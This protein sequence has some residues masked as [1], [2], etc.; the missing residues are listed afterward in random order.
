MKLSF[1]TAGAVL[2][3]AGT[4]AVAAPQES[5]SQAGGTINGTF[6]SDGRAF[7]PLNGVATFT[8]TGTYAPKRLIIGG[9]LTSGG[10]GSWQL[11][12]SI[13]VTPPSGN[14]FVVNASVLGATYT[15]FNLP[16]NFAAVTGGP[17]SSAA[18]TW[19]LRFYETW[20]DASIDATW[21]N[22][23]VTLDD[24][25]PAFPAVPGTAFASN[26]WTDVD[27]DGTATSGTPTVLT[28]EYTGTSN[29]SAV[30]IG[31][32]AVGRTGFDINKDDTQTGE[33][34]VGVTP[35]GGTEIVRQ[36]AAGPRT[37]SPVTHA[38]LVVNL[39]GPT[40]PGTWT[41]RLFEGSRNGDAVA[42]DSGVD[43][44]WRRFFLALLPSDPPASETLNL[45]DGVFVTDTETLSGTGVKWYSFTI[46]AID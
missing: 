25:D 36:I 16:A 21:S 35:P 30:S 8:A 13:L 11:E 46:P 12:S 34:R 33:L 38:G 42:D 37:T 2:A 1:V 31:G 39:P 40:A 41:V 19:E 4:W 20:D 43:N 26:V 28:W 29:A 32:L 5:F 23:T 18:G 45:V 3:A 10:V 22:L 14:S 9:T 7:S 27:S 15:V 17:I 6:Q 44:T 24:A